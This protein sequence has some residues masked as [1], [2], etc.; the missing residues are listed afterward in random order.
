MLALSNFN[1][2][3]PSDS[4]N[5]VGL[6]ALSTVFSVIFCICSAFLGNLIIDGFARKLVA[7]T[8]VFSSVIAVVLATN[9]DLAD[10]TYHTVLALGIAMCYGLI[11]IPAFGWIC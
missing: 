3:S 8:T 1:S 10:A 7:S 9:F 2:Y 5:W 4:K 11:L 6:N